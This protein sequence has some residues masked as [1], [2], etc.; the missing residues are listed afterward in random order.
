MGMASVVVRDLW[1]S[2]GH[3][4]VLK[5][6]SLNLEGPE[7]LCIAGPNGSGKTTLLK[8]IDGILRPKRGIILINGRDLRE[9]KR[10]EIARIISYVPQNESMALSFP[11]VLEVVLAGRRPYITWYPSERD[12]EKAWESLSILGIEDLAMRN[13]NELSG[14]EKQKVL[15]ARALAQEAEV[16]LLDEPTSNLDLKYQ[17]EVMKLVRDLTRSKEF[18]TMIAMHDLNLISTYCDRVL[19]MKE[20]VLLS[21]GEP[22]SVLTRENIKETYGVEVLLDK[23]FGRPFII[24]IG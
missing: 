23:S 6:I 17:I 19:L 8:C 2:Y 7:V 11:R 21:I 9:M 3:R 20:G 22:S 12:V 10:L 16:L 24:P 13:I 15:L 1:F 5:G 14:G 18:S 4:D